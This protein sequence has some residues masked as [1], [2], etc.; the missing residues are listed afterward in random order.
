MPGQIRPLW[1]DDAIDVQG[2]GLCDLFQGRHCKAVC[3]DGGGYSGVLFW[4]AAGLGQAGLHLN[5]GDHGGA[6]ELDGVV[7]QDNHVDVGCAGRDRGLFRLR[8]VRSCGQ[9]ECINAGL[10]IQNQ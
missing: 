8:A 2:A 5:F 4:A 7:D 9:Q 6:K 10:Y 1:A 3:V